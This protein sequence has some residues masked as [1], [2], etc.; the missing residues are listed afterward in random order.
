MSKRSENSTYYH[1]TAQKLNE[2][3]DPVGEKTYFLTHKDIKE[4]LNIPRPTLYR[5]AKFP[6]RKKKGKYPYVI[7]KIYIH[8]DVVSYMS[9]NS[10]SENEEE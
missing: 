7:E 5:M 2:D 8:K 1:Y 10:S 9:A 6:E 3:G 4:K